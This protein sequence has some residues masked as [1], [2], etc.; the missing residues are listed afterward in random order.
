VYALDEQ[1]RCDRAEREQ[2]AIRGEF[3][4]ACLDARLNF[5]VRRMTGDPLEIL[6]RESQFHDL[7]IT[8][9]A[10]TSADDDLSPPLSRDDLIELLRRGVQPLLV[11]PPRRDEFRRVLLA[12]DGGESSG[13]AIRG[14]LGL[15]IFSGATHRLLAAVPEADL[16]QTHLREMAG[17]CL[18]RRPGLE[19]GYVCG[20]LRRVVAS[21]AEKWDADLIVIGV[22][23][24]SSLMRR[25]RGDAVGDLLK[26][27]DFGLFVTA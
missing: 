1:W 11:V 16:A 13:R 4:R 14:F 2:E 21:Y 17:Y 15:D 22:D 19:A 9:Q 7:V 23:G 6:P 12:Y 26:R 3:S 27:G 20:D 8:S 5:D 25:L 24:G 18:H 10:T